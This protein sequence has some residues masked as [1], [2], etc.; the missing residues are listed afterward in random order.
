M[1]TLPNTNSL[2]R[3]VLDAQDMFPQAHRALPAIIIKVV[4]D[5]IRTKPSDVVFLGKLNQLV[6]KRDFDLLLDAV[7]AAVLGKAVKAADKDNPDLRSATPDWLRKRLAYLADGGT[8]YQKLPR[9]AAK[10]RTKRAEASDDAA[11]GAKKA[12]SKTK[13]TDPTKARST[14]AK[15][16]G[17]NRDA[18]ET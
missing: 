15:W 3:V 7:P 10:P 4:V 12:G 18:E 9:P 2:L 1:S 8:P 6:G 14:K 13:I 16:D 17:K 11:T 5:E